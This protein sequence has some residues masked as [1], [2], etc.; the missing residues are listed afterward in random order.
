M[1]KTHCTYVFWYC[2]FGVR[3]F[4]HYFYPDVRSSCKP[5]VAMSKPF[6]MLF[7]L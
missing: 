7:S 2:K 5:E 3:E 4:S 6:Y 1:V